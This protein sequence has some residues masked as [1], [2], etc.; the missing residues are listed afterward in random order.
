MQHHF[1]DDDHP[2]EAEPKVSLQI[3]DE[4]LVPLDLFEGVLAELNHKIES[5][6]AVHL[7]LAKSCRD[8]QVKKCKALGIESGKQKG[9]V[10][11]SALAN[12]INIKMEQTHSQ[13]F[14]TLFKH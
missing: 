14:T 2:R 3:T 4:D 9:E 5:K 11:K 6:R 8:E 1:E 12:F 13:K 10:E 7:E